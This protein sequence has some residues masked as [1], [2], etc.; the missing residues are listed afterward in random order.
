VG[1]STDAYDAHGFDPGRSPAR[2]PHRPV[3]IPPANLHPEAFPAWLA[4]TDASG[5]PCPSWP[6]RWVFAF[7]RARGRARGEAGRD[8]RHNRYRLLTPA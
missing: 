1:F 5:F 6:W 4:R 8:N 7:W 3:L 2:P